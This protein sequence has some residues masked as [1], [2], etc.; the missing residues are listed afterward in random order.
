MTECSSNKRGHK[1]PGNTKDQI[2]KIKKNKIENLKNLGQKR[3]QKWAKTDQNMVKIKTNDCHHFSGSKLHNI[4]A[5]AVCTRCFKNVGKKW[6][7][8]GA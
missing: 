1:V 4:M 2:R 6:A 3:A 7:K 5:L 8:K